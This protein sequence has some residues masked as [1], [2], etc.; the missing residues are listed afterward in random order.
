MFKRRLGT[1][2]WVSNPTTQR[3]TVFSEDASV[4]K[5]IMLFFSFSR[6]FN[7]VNGSD[8]QLTINT[9]ASRSARFFSGIKSVIYTLI[10][11]QGQHFLPGQPCVSGS[12][13]TNCL[14]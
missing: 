1:M 8:C 5:K 9:K 6:W 13:Q 3:L 2:V 14:F 4:S 12:H 7:S 11:R 10:Y